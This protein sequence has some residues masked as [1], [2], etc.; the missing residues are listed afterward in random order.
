VR[1][2]LSRLP[3]PRL[4]RTA[5]P[6]APEA[7]ETQDPA[8]VESQV[9]RLMWEQVGLVRRRD[10]LRAALARFDALAAGRLDAASQSLV[11]VARLV[12]TAALARTESRGAHFRSDH[13]AT[14]PAW[15][16][17]ILLSPDG[18]GIRVDTE[19]VAE[20]EAVEACA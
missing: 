19:A 12:A 6:A 15:R 13:P 8:E 14:E 18:P 2:A 16:R 7:G 4:D 3:V 1:E 11:T 17:R 20:P 9:R 5:R 10:G